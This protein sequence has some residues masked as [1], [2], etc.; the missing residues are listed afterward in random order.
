MGN[1]G[2]PCCYHGWF[3]VPTT[4]LV[5]VVPISSVVI[6]IPSLFPKI[7]STMASTDR[8]DFYW[9]WGSRRQRDWRGHP[10]RHPRVKCV[11][12][13]W[14]RQL[15]W[16]VV[17][18]SEGCWYWAYRKD[19]MN[20]RCLFGIVDRLSAC[21]NIVFWRNWWCSLEKLC[22]LSVELLWWFGCRDQE[23]KRNCKSKRFRRFVIE[24]SW[25]W[26]N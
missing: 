26:P 5:S 23:P 12:W 14:S 20:W 10:R 19:C 24:I 3:H 15:R 22:R 18:G 7:Y 17:K 21:S 25:G 13:G 11:R 2:L 8:T 16:F 9:T 6:T 4:L 1:S